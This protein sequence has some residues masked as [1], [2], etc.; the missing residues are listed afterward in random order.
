MQRDIAE[1][2]EWATEGNS[3][4]LKV[5]AI[6]YCTSES[7]VVNNNDDQ[8]LKKC[9]QSRKEKRERNGEIVKEKGEVKEM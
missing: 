6:F 7:L 8:V 4:H 2:I 5:N 9:L 3:G 1:V